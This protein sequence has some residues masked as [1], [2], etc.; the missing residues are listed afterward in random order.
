MKLPTALLWQCRDGTYRMWSAVAGRTDKFRNLTQGLSEFAREV[1]APTYEE[2][3]SVFDDATAGTPDG[4][5]NERERIG[6]HHLPMC[7]L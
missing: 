7:W 3:D 2:D 4:P 5:G 1:V 6:P